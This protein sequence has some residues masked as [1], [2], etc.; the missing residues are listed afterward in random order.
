MKLVKIGQAA[1]MLGVTP[2][3][4]RVWDKTGEQEL[5]EDV[6]EIITVF[7]AK[8]YGSRSKKHREVME[9]VRN[10]VSS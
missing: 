9:T 3:T 10:A 5:A 8:L 2:E 6:L 7:S 1:K 4:L